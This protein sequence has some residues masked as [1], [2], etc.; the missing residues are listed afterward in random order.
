MKPYT[1][2]VIGV[3]YPNPDG[4][5]RQD[6][7]AS[8]RRDTPIRLES[9]PTNAYDPNAIAVKVATEP[10]K[11]QQVGYIPKELA[12]TIAPLMQ[13]ESLMARIV[14][15]TGGFE[16]WDGEIAALGLVIV[17]EVPDPDDDDEYENGQRTIDDTYGRK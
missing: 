17:I 12:K 10:G 7:I 4:S 14:S 13:G 2:K 5:N 3:T 15:I 8:C 11:V 1:T 6:I 9:E 16:T